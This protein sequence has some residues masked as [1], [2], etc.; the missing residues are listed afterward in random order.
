MLKLTDGSLNWTDQRL[1]VTPVH[2]QGTILTYDAMMYSTR[3]K[4]NCVSKQYGRMCDAPVQVP[5]ILSTTQWYTWPEEQ[6]IA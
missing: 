4:K 3:G 2:G 6:R 1:R 5:A